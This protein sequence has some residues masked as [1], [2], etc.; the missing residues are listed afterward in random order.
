MTHQKQLH[1]EAVM[2]TTMLAGVKRKLATATPEM[3]RKLPRIT[4]VSS[5]AK[6]PRLE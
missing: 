6:V 2:G 3:Q 4:P 5:A 1:H